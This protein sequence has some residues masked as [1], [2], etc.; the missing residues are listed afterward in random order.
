MEIIKNMDLDPEDYESNLMLLDLFNN[1]DSDVARETLSASREVA[2]VKKEA[3]KADKEYYKK[4]IKEKKIKTR[5]AEYE[6]AYMDAEDLEQSILPPVR[7]GLVDISQVQRAPIGISGFS[8]ASRS[9]PQESIRLDLTQ[10]GKI[11]KLPSS[12][13]TATSSTSAMGPNFKGYGCVKKGLMWR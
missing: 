1:K 6:E 8:R 5:E 10:K 2:R 11:I 7:R 4:N 3:I 9:K 13:T 12:V